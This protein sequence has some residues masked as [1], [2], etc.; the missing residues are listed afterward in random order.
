M[1]LAVGSSAM[2]S[3]C[4][5]TTST[6]ASSAESTE[7]D[8][9]YSY[10]AS[11]AESA[12]E[13]TVSSEEENLESIIDFTNLQTQIEE[14]I[15]NT[16]YNEAGGTWS[17]YVYIPESGDSLSINNTPMAAASVIK[18]YIMGAVFDEYE[19]ICADYPDVDVD[20][21][22]EQM[23]TVSD[24]DCA[25]E[26]INMLGRG[27]NEAGKAAINEFCET[28]GFSGTTVERMMHDDDEV[29]DNYTTTEDCAMFLNMV[30]NGEFEYSTQ[31]LDYL[32]AQTV[33]YKIP[34]GVTG[35]YLIANKTG[36]LD[37]VQNDVAIVYTDTPYI[38]CVMSNEVLQY[39]APIETIVEISEVTC[40]YIA[41]YAG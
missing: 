23:I 9:A 30:Y 5:E 24:N 1:A 20:Y 6:E 34:E 36:E 21:L 17:V 39:V 15:E 14:I 10:T 8:A 16:Q 11:G 29:I 35:A 32:C 13:L 41:A 4:S 2:L 3:S 33:T 22:L 19:E 31:M 25:D 40:D 26:L 7:T 37:D 12:E 27:D 28:Y 18:I 38:I